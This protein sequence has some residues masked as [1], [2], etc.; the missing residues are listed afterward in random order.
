MYLS[1]TLSAPGATPGGRHVL[2]WRKPSL[3]MFSL[4]PRPRAPRERV[5]SGDEALSPRRPD[6]DAF[7][8]S[9]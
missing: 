9:V 3:I 7:G 1:V 8:E 5:G 2:S 6:I 4:V